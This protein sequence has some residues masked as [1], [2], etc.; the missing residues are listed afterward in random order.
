MK[1]ILYLMVSIVLVSLS[2]CSTCP[3][4]EVIIEHRYLKMPIPKTKIQPEFIPYEIKGV[5]FN[6][7]DYY[8][9]RRIDGNIMLN[10]WTSYKNWAEINYNTL[11]SIED[12]N[13]TKEK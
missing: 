3:E 8:F 9:M 11:K 2:G 13:T 7:E 10:N 6:G 5:N 12:F 4:P 1:W